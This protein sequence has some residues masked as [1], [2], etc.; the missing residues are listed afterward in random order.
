MSRRPSD[1]GFTLIELIVVMLLMGVLMAMGAFSFVN[2][3]RTSEQRG[4]T[5]QIVSVLR[6]ASERA[7]SEGR[8]Y[9]VALTNGTPASSNQSYSLWQRACT[10]AGGGTQVKSYSTQSTRVSFVPSVTAVSPAPACASGSA[11]IYFY[12]RGTATPASLVVA[13]S[14]RSKTYTVRVEGLT[15]RVYL[16]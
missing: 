1:E 12:P 3:Q 16:S 8:T 11:C 14:A 2:Y 10:T 13:S 15:A 7:V 4:S 5:Q 9:C 6:S